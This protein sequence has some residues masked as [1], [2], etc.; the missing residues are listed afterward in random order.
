MTSWNMDGRLDKMYC[1]NF[2]FPEIDNKYCGY[3]R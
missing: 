2:E 1:I 3:I